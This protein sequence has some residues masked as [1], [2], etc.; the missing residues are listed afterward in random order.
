MYKSYQLKIKAWM[1]SDISISSLYIW[2]NRKKHNSS[3][4]DNNR[5]LKIHQN[6]FTRIFIF[7]FAFR[8]WHITYWYWNIS[9]NNLY[10]TNCFSSK[11]KCLSLFGKSVGKRYTTTIN[12]FCQ[13]QYSHVKYLRVFVIW[14]GIKKFT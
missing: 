12:T 10:K 7:F 11:V 9:E 13:F 14:F 6:K 8:T 5:M 3:S 1:H 4:L 2:I